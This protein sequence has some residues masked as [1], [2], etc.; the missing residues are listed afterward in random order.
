MSPKT[1]KAFLATARAALAAPPSKHPVPLHFVVG[2]ESADLDSL[3]STLLLA[4]F[5]SYP[6]GSGGDGG[7][8]HIPLCHLPREDLALRPEFG[9][10]L[11]RAAVTPDDVLTLSELPGSGGAAAASAPLRPEDTNWLLVD[12]NVMTGPLGRA[13]GG[14]VAG[15][16][17]HH[18]DEGAVPSRAVPRVIER[19]GSCMSLVV[20]QCAGAWARM[21]SAEEDGDGSATAAATAAATT[22]GGGGGSAAV[23]AQLAYL[24][25]APILVDTANLGNADKTTARDESAVAIAEAK[26]RSR[27]VAYDRREFFDHV[28]ALKEDIS[29]LSLRDVLRKDYKEWVEEAAAAAAAAE[30]GA[31]PE[32]APLKLGTSSVPQPFAGLVRKAAAAEEEEEEEEEEAEARLVAE[33]EAWAAEKG[34][35][36]L[37][38]LTAS[39]AGGEGGAFVRE[40]LVWARTGPEVV[41]AMRAFAT[42]C[43]AELGLGTWGG[44]KLDVSGDGDG[45]SSWRRCWTQARVENSRKQIAPMLREALRGALKER[46]ETM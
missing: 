11:E 19:C 17:D 6:H 4:Y 42:A 45:G 36:V 38:V 12:H 23:D 7:P 40:L 21:S 24:A 44:G 32:V 20:D 8:L 27:G 13:Y 9:A 31:R 37:A 30:A 15:C 33:L 29:R 1:L 41:R 34:L 43:G 22:G 18:E 14:R 39:R 3:C 26:L 35:D 5:R 46:T 16:V 10:V 25:L 28:S 2:N